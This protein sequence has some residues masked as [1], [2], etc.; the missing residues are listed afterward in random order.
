MATRKKKAEAPELDYEPAG[1]HDFVTVVS[2][3]REGTYGVV[4]D[5]NNEGD[6]IV[7]SRDS[8]SDRFVVAP[9]A[10]RKSEAGLR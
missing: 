4:I 7:R 6:F 9:D 3:D 5:T 10:V 1:V 2:G 8:N